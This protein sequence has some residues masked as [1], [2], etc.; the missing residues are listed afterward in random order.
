MAGTSGLGTATP[1]LVVSH[2]LLSSLYLQV[3]AVHWVS[4][5]FRNKCCPL[6]TDKQMHTNSCVCTLTK[7][8][9]YTPTRSMLQNNTFVFILGFFLGFAL[10]RLFPR[11]GHSSSCF[12]CPC[13][14]HSCPSCHCSC[15]SR[16]C[17]SSVCL[18]SPCC[19]LLLTLLHK[20]TEENR[21]LNNATNTWDLLQE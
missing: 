3:G 1:L 2:S 9:T 8:H 5:L 17:C 18:I 7:T 19:C 12:S 21:T 10:P 14:R 4:H 15:C 11:A 20:H 16:S 13:S 6:H